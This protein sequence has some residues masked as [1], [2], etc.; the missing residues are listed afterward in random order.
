[1]TR[2]IAELARELRDAAG[3]HLAEN[4]KYYGGLPLPVLRG[5]D[6]FSSDIQSIGG[7]FYHTCI[8]SVDFSGS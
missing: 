4:K 2:G 1:M 6:E 8:A 5:S 7:Q 3:V